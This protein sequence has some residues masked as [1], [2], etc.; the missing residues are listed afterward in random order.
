MMKTLICIVS[1][2]S[3]CLIGCSKDKTTTPATNRAPAAPSNPLPAHQATGVA[4]NPQL[5]WQCSDPDGDSLTYDIY[6]GNQQ[7]PPLADSNYHG[8]SYQPTGLEYETSY[9]WKVAAK[10]NHGTVTQGPVWVFTTMAQAH[11]IYT[12]ATYR[13]PSGFPGSVIVNGDTAVIGIYGSYY[14]LGF[15]IINFDTP[16]SPSLIGQYDGGYL[17][18]VKYVS[19]DFVYLISGAEYGT[20]FL[21][22]VDI[23]NP[24]SPRFASSYDGYNYYSIVSLAVSEPVAC[25]MLDNSLVSL[26]TISVGNPNSPY[27]L[28]I[29]ED[30]EYDW[31][32][33]D[34]AGNNAYV[35]GQRSNNPYT[36]TLGIIDIANP[37]A[38]ILVGSCPTGDSVRANGI[39]VRENYAYAVTPLGLKIFNISNTSN[40][41]II[42]TYSNWGSEAFCLAGNYIY[43]CGRDYGLDIVDVSNPS[44]PVLIANW[45]HVFIKGVSASTRYIYA[46]DGLD[47]YVLQYVP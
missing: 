16:S 29:M 31:Q 34:I 3:M 6:F 9:Y 45:N 37:V 42:G 22:I 17:N 1:C 7:A 2:L 47:L 38:P 32:Y 18:Q 15:Q 33:V 8:C 20:P 26:E 27:H 13:P 25:L 5:A 36:T 23:S 12:I 21:K 28:G 44:I 40:P 19:N 4:I 10:D 14:S 41:H 30:F 43:L 39:R 35:I 24:A 46:V 11:G